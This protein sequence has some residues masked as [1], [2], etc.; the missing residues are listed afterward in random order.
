MFVQIIICISSKASV[1]K[2]YVETYN[3][4]NLLTRTCFASKFV[5]SFLAL[6]YINWYRNLQISDFQISRFRSLGWDELDFLLFYEVLFTLQLMLS[7]INYKS[8]F[9][10][11]IISCP[12]LAPHPSKLYLFSF[13]LWEVGKIHI[14]IQLE[15]LWK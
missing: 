12:R 7:N 2:L 11:T 1:L 14:V 6:V 8:I 10:Y 4:K 15:I 3:L 5:K 13:K 9:I